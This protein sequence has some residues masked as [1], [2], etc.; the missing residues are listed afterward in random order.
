MDLYIT[1][2]RGVKII[3]IG[4]KDAK[5]YD[6]C[7][8]LVHKRDNSIPDKNYL[9]LPIKDFVIGDTWNFETNESNKD[10]SIRFEPKPKSELELLQEQVEILKLKVEK[11]ELIK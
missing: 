11:L 5:I 6:V 4:I 10:S 3:K 2:Q 7:S 8:K 9:D 1:G